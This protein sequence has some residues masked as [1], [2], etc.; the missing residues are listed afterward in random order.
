MVFKVVDGQLT[1]MFKTTQKLSTGFNTVVADLNAY[2]D[3]FSNLNSNQNFGKDWENF[4]NGMNQIDPNLPTYFQDLA[5]QGASAQASIK[6]MYAAMLNGNT[7]GIQNVKAIVSAFNQ[8]NPEQQKA[9]ASAVGQ[10]NARLGTYLGNLKGAKASMRGYGTQLVSA[11]A[12]TV[13]LTVASTALNAAISMVISVAISLLI[14][15]ITSLINKTQE[16]IDK[17]NEASQAV[18]E[19]ENA[20][21]DYID[22][23]VELRGKLEDNN[24]T[25]QESVNIKKDLSDIQSEIIDKYGDEA[26]GLDLVTGSIEDQIEAMYKLN[27][28]KYDEQYSLNKEGYDAARE[29]VQNATATINA[30]RVL[31]NGIGRSLAPDVLALRKRIANIFDE[32]GFKRDTSYS[33]K[34]TK[35]FLTGDMYTI[36]EALQNVYNDIKTYSQNGSE[37]V[38][39]AADV[40]MTYISQV[41]R[42]WSNKTLD[43]NE[44]LYSQWVK[45][46]EE[47]SDTYIGIVR[48]QKRLEYALE[49]KN[50]EDIANARIEYTTEY[51][52][53]IQKAIENGDADVAKYLEKIFGKTVKGIDD[54]KISTDNF[55]LSVDSLNE[56]L[57]KLQELLKDI[58]S[59]SNTYQSAMQKI[60]AGVGLTTKE[61][62]DILELDPTLFDKFV[63]QDNGTWTIDLGALKLSYDTII[64]DGGEKAIA[65]EKKTYQEVLDNANAE[66]E[67]LQQDRAER[68]SYIPSQYAYQELNDLDKRI[69]EVKN[70]IQKAKNDLNVADFTLSELDYNDVDRIRDSYDGFIKKIDGYNDSVSSLNQAIDSINEG[71]SLSYEDMTKL[72]ELYPELKDKVTETQDGYT[73]VSTA[74]EEVR[75]QAY[76]TRDDY[77]DSLIDATQALKDTVDLQI[78]EF[79]RRATEFIACENACGN[80]ISTIDEYLADDPIYKQLA[81][82]VEFYDEIMNKL[83]GY[84]NAVKEPDS[85]SSTK[86]KNKEITDS[87]QNQ[88][89]YYTNLLNAISAVADR[90]IE[91]LE[92]EK[93]AID[94]KID[95]LNDE[96]DALQE[97]NDEQ[98]RELD[99]IEAQNNLDKAKKQKV[100]VYK[101]GAGLVQVQDEKAIKDAQKEL[102][103]VKAKIREA[104]IDKQIG[105][106]EK[107]NEAL[108]SQIDSVNEYKSVFSDME[109]NAKDQLSIEQAKKV[110][111]TDEKGLLSLSEK[112][113]SGIRN[114]LA[115]AL[116]NKDVEDNKNNDK[117][118]NITLDD[119]L[120]GLG[121]SVTSQQFQAIAKM[122]NGNIPIS[123]PI[124]N[125]TV[126]NA[127]SIVNNKTVTLNNTFNVYD[128]KDSDTVIEQIKDYMSK[129]LRT[130]INSIK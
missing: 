35:F 118:V 119:F 108:D 116:Y 85:S 30:D 44:E 15:I 60:T 28:A 31:A 81:S 5:K 115:T 76:K 103:D 48:K 27:K 38:K 11:T 122:A 1:N 12:K 32:Y 73:I 65:D 89:D 37:E 43:D 29:Q 97:K 10:T 2:T 53:A 95:S 90:Q 130:A 93:D 25:E 124:T 40:A 129:T 78:N 21:D 112:T 91:A 19:Q 86:S 9:F 69:E 18:T 102:D 126:N 26:K 34:P 106:Y 51:N 72:V 128:S 41:R 82:Q 7:S 50:A 125:S 117:Y 22:K 92:K 6:G 62:N 14:K 52:N 109:S 107:Q 45:N 3:E 88:I 101:E 58:L 56:A 84:K 71:N 80:F 104:E 110:F 121:A 100:F 20:I 127:Q 111:N 54:I 113:V 23:I 68:A 49:S 83:L 79:R 105:V 39:N 46:G 98:Q 66:L 17:A 99:L 55:T 33:G 94:K 16:A 13:A 59:G 114:G 42:D 67:K 70:I 64:V 75:Q 63:K 74:L 61:V 47:Y 120:K 24:L 8:M 87:L 123:T 77:I 96:K 36:D 57:T 4:L